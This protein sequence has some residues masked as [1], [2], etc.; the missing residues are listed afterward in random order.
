MSSAYFMDMEGVE[1]PRTPA[2]RKL[3]SM[4]ATPLRHR[5]ILSEYLLAKFVEITL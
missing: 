1:V 2:E 3:I 4:R 5:P